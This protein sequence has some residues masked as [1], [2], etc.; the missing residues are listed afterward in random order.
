MLREVYESEHQVFVFK[1]VV[2]LVTTAEFGGQEN[3]LRFV[4]AG[5]AT[6]VVPLV[7][8]SL[9]KVINI[10][11]SFSSWLLRQFFLLWFE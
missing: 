8:L 5:G 6:V 10:P 11:V 9:A 1:L 7:V 2:F 4:R 3:A